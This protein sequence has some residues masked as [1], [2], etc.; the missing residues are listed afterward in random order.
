MRFVPERKKIS[1]QKDP[2]VSDAVFMSSRDGQNW[3]RSHLEAWLRLVRMSGIGRIAATCL[4]GVSC[5]P[6]RTSSR[7]TSASTIGWPDNRLR[8]VT[9]RRHGFA[10]VHAAYKGGEFTTRALNFAGD[11]LIVNYA[12]SAAGIMQLKFRTKAVRAIPGFALRRYAA[13]L[14]RRARC[15][16]VLDIEA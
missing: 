6:A 7:C 2:G 10:S 16:G 13:A 1:E 14:W 5:R 11:K 15:C 8:R 12:T 4:P 3:D 9:V